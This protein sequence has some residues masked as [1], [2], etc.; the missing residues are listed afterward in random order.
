MKNMLQWKIKLTDE[1]VLLGAEPFRDGRIRITA[2]LPDGHI[3][4]C[5]ARVR[6]PLTDDVRI[7]MNG[8]Q[9]WTDCPEYT[10]TDRI[11][12]ID[13]LPKFVI[14]KYSL[15]RYSDY[16][17]MDYPY[18]RG[19]THGYSYCWFRK[20]DRYFLIGSLDERPGYTMFMYNANREILTI[21]RDCEGLRCRGE[22]SAFD[23]FLA[24]GT[25]DEVFD[26]WFDALGN[27]CRTKEK[28]A[29]YSSWYNRY[30]NISERS[31]MEDL[32]GAKQVLSPGDV[33]QIDDGWEPYV[34][35]WLKADPEKFPNEMKAA[36]DAIHEAGFR[37][38]LWLA[39]FIAEEK[40]QLFKEHPEWF[41]FHEGMPW[42]AGCN[43]SG[44]YALDI[45]KPEVI[46]YLRETFRQVLDVWEYDLV[47]L[48]F[49][50]A[51]A[52]FGSEE[53]S[54]ASRMIRAVDLLRELCGEKLILGC[55]VPLFP[56]FGKV[57]YCRVSCDV[58][59]DY[60]D[61]LF[62]RLIH[63]E[64]PSTKHAIATDTARR[65]LN[66]RAF[67]NDPDVFFLRTENLSLSEEKK[68][69]L[70]ETCALHGNVL[71]TSDN[72][73][74]YNEKQRA[75]YRRIRTIFEERH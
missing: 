57:D 11:R 71:F 7:F 9:S 43:W 36:A 10:K 63:R 60:N 38:G 22:F 3:A 21:R 4:S 61:K 13:H 30:Q 35:D 32:E 59:L 16:H 70:A 27:P 41:L 58:S 31:I 55:G 25:E 5:A 20:N 29:G 42:K 1:T 68:R 34:G 48:D 6:L 72:M 47:K 62:M 65:H 49:L 17:F 28:I 18:R 69:A 53:E 46:G 51:A 75:E 54:R 39:P 52:P 24:E 14:D 50:Y 8:Y 66:G 23:L 74:V 15:D 26:A 45:D 56:A 67:G 2:D 40:S 64:R 37:A 44:Y 73:S 19:Y 33:F 12:G